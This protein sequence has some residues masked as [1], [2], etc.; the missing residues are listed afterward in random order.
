MGHGEQ[1]HATGRAPRHRVLS[2]FTHSNHI[3]KRARQS[4]GPG[5]VDGGSAT[6]HLLGGEDLGSWRVRPGRG[7]G[8][9]ENDDG[10]GSCI[11]PAFVLQKKRRE[12]SREGLRTTV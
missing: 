8:V 7:E 11:F 6:D 12:A 1:L 10:N 5:S 4:S 9:H 2:G 3:A